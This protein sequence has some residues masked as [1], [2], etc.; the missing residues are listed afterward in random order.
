VDIQTQWVDS[1]FSTLDLDAK[2][3]QLFMVAAYSNKDDAH[4][5]E[6]LELVEDYKIGG[7]I[8][9]QGGPVRQANL[10]NEYQAAADVPLLVAMDCEWGVGMRLDST[11]RYP[12]QMALGAVQDNDLIYSMGEEIARQFRRLGMHINFAPV[13][14]VN[15]NARN[16]VINFRSFGEDKYN[17]AE[18]GLAYMKGMQDH[19]ILACGKHFPGHGDTE[20]DSHK[21]LPVISHGMDR[22]KDIELYPFHELMKKGLGS[23][24]VAHLSIPVLDSTYNL[25][26]TLSSPIVSGL[27][28]DSLDFAG[29]VFTDA[30]NMEGVAKYYDPGEV[31]LKA[32]MAGNDVLLFSMN[33]QKGIGLIK[34]AVGDGNVSQE[35]IDESVKK[36]LALKYW[37]GLI[38]S[39]H[40][41]TERL[42]ED[43]NTAEAKLL[44]R[45]LVEASLTVI[46]NEG[47]I[48]PL[49][50]LD[51]LKITSITI[52]NSSKKPFDE[53]LSTYT[54]INHVLLSEEVNMDELSGKI[55]D[56]NLVILNVTGLSQYASR[57][58]GLSAIKLALIN[59]ILKNHPTILVW[60]GNPYGLA[61]LESID[62]S[63][64]TIISY[65][66]N[67]NTFDLSAQLLFGGISA[68]GKL[69]VSINLSYPAGTG[70][71]IEGD[72]RLGY[73]MPEEV[74]LNGSYLTKKLDSLAD[75]TLKEEVAPGL[76]VLVA[77]HGKVVFHKAWGHH[78]YDR[79][80]EVKKTDIY[81]FASVTKIT[82]AL[83][84]LMKMHDEE[85]FDLDATLGTYLDYFDRRNKK[86][87][88]IRR[89]LSHNAGLQSW[90][91]YWTTTIK[92]NGKYKRNTLSHDSTAKYSI[93]LTGDL[94]LYNRYKEKIYK[95][96][97]KSPVN[98]DQGYV[99]SGL[100][101][102]L[103]PEVLQNLT[104]EEYEN[105]LKSTFY[106]PIGANTL[107]FNPYKHFSLNQI[108][109]TENDTF[110]RKVQIHGVVHD[111]GAAMMDGLSANAGLFGSANDL[112]KLMQ[113]YLNMGTYGGERFISENTL[114]KFTFRHYENE[115]IRRGLGFDKP[116][117]ENKE[118]G[119]PAKDAGENSFGHSGY[120]GMFTWAD[121]DTGILFVFCSNRVYPTRENNKI[122]RLSIRPKMHQVVYDARLD[123]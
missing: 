5:Q 80:R 32:F 13:I 45:K 97:L 12:Y 6:I 22:L 21:D 118:N 53:R 55:P 30:L 49:K 46:R 120:T 75:Y 88:I 10:H 100:S 15:N 105:Y 116:V 89:I 93:K 35:E 27:L 96:I 101:F 47:D 31:D 95:M 98:P 74:D 70:M 43:L 72:M 4:R 106:R 61:M 14:D 59:E 44:N 103:W 58:F 17:V 50:G 107:T 60:H 1:V 37:S 94:Y 119:L 111:E 112:A 109:P 29:M 69:P 84:G 87:I 78:T 7:L 104:G 123:K 90:I 25:P 56:S 115:G 52:D 40:V 81:D 28:K 3:G 79:N 36:I 24:M 18:K 20:V 9:F 71:A 33:V 26:S 65:Q 85:K 92:K 11:I 23:V 73:T 121:P 62:N 82:S 54:D 16:P 38:K 110:F 91:A 76:Q 48:L 34:K 117:L 19:G 57:N 86:D 83:P 64:A 67:A 41:E 102:Y 113:M 108:L 2:I 77:R 39:Q 68:H 63:Q 42:I 122:A 114:R 99:Y 51:S 8:F 66:E